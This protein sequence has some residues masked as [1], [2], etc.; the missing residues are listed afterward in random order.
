MKAH[1]TIVAAT[2]KTVVT[3][4]TH[5]GCPSAFSSLIF[6]PKIDVLKL[7]GTKKIASTVTNNRISKWA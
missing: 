7:I 4:K 3:I 2:I 1:E 6:I 5:S